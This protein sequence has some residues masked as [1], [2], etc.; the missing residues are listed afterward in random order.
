MVGG[1]QGTPQTWDGVPPRPKMGT[2][3]PTWD[4]VPPYLRWDTPLPGVP[5][6]HYTEQ[7]SEHLL[8]F[9]RCASCVHAGRLS[10]LWFCFYRFPR[11]SLRL[12]TISYSYFFPK[13]DT[14]CFSFLWWNHFINF[15]KKI[16]LD[17]WFWNYFCWRDSWTPLKILS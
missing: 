8:H 12:L 16:K 17:F 10:C 9:G 5:P 15:L 13:S 7:H 3:P 2:P 4:G 6:P 11:A 14:C 1:T